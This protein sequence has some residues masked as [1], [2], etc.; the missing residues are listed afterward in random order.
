MGTIMLSPWFIAINAALTLFP[1]ISYGVNKNICI[2]IS[3]FMAI[4]FI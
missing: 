4:D 1:G 3:Y 2:T